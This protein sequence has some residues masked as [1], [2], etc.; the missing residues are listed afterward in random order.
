LRWIDSLESELAA[1]TD[2]DLVQR[3]VQL[4]AASREETLDDGDVAEGIALVREVG[5]RV[6]GLRL[7][8][9]QV[10]AAV[11]LF[12]G[13]IA[14]LATGEGKT[15]AAVAPAWLSSLSGR[16]VHVLTFNDYLAR[17]DAAWMGP[18]FEFLGSS[19]GCIQDGMSR[20]ERG[21]AYACDVTYATAK[22]AGFDYLHDQRVLDAKLRVHRP[23]HHAIV[24]EA[25]SLLIDEA[26]VPLVLAGGAFVLPV[27]PRALTSIVR[28]L[29]PDLD[30]EIDEYARNV[31]L[32]ESGVSTAERLLELPNLHSETHRDVLT[33]LNLAL[34]AEVLLR[35]DVDYI[36]RDGRIEVVD[37]FTGRVVADR[38]WPDGLHPALEAKD[39]LEVGTEGTVLTSIALQHYFLLYPKLSGMTATA[40]PAAEELHEF[41]GLDVAVI[42]SHRNCIRAD[43]VDAVFTDRSSKLE[44]IVEAVRDAHTTGRPVLVGTASVAES[45]SFAAVLRTAEIDCEVLNA[46]N[47]EAEARIIAEAGRL[48]AV[49]ISTNMAGRGTDIRLGGSSEGAAPAV[50]AL[51]GLYVIGTNKHESRRIDDQLRGRAGRQGDPGSS[52]FFVSL[53]DDLTERYGITGAIDALAEDRNPGRIESAAV[54]AEVDRAQR[55]VEGQNFDIR[56]TLWKYSSM[57]EQQRRI[58]AEY[59]DHAL[60]DPSDID[61]FVRLRDERHAEIVERFGSQ[62]AERIEQRIVLIETDRAWC[63]HLARIADIREGIHLHYLAGQDSFGGIWTL[64]KTPL[65]V[66]HEMAVEAFRVTRSRLDEAILSSYDEL[67]LTD[68]GV[69]LD[70]DELKGPESTWTYIVND[71]PFESTIIRMYRAIRKAPAPG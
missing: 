3:S 65:D 36:V 55:I 12:Q 40:V 29:R 18:I 41:Y 66:F 46:K 62:T 44:A 63:S 16:G 42:P 37:E 23:F 33:A 49:T 9:V 48:G 50:V 19:V 28:S 13:R 52:R 8:E 47:D 25:D 35:R 59:R 45:E 32:T 15:L 1:A 53:E 2:D 68:D 4:R 27:D 64:R 56:R 67:E 54:I 51:G 21:R 43:E 22:Q 57:I 20:S 31:T 5:D 69:N 26:R 58:L 24:D 39:G 10:L 38:R 11:A 70:R 71:T 30:Y 61:L 34:H 6:L 14:E 60:L 17:R 7:H